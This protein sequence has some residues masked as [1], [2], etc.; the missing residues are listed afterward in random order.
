MVEAADGERCSA[1]RLCESREMYEWVGE[2][3]KEGRGE[4][5]QGKYPEVSQ[6]RPSGVRSYP[7]SP[8]RAQG[9]RQSSSE[10][11]QVAGETDEEPRARQRSVDRPVEKGRGA[12]GERAQARGTSEGMHRFER[13]HRSA[14]QNGNGGSDKKA[15]SQHFVS[16]T[17]KKACRAGAHQQ[18]LDTPDM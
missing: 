1:I 17:G 14:F 18:L 12:E 9:G 16:Q 11:A 13:L 15:C 7:P 5:A 2:A 6:T 10:F 4:R 8:R 3:S